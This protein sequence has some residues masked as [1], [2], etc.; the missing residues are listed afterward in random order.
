MLV[1][2]RTVYYFSISS[3]RDIQIVW[4]SFLEFFKIWKNIKYWLRKKHPDIPN[5]LRVKWRDMAYAIAPESDRHY[6]KE[7]EPPIWIRPEGYTP[8][9]KEAQIKCDIIIN[10]MEASY[11]NYLMEWLKT[12]HPKFYWI[13]RLKII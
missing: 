3:K 12:N 8:E 6:L 13:R 1:L 11:D 4:K 9:Q 5:E 7:N 2:E 10:K